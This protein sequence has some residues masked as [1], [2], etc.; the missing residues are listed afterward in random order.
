MLPVSG[1]SE[2]EVSTSASDGT[3]GFSEYASPSSFPAHA[4]R[5]A[6]SATQRKSVIS[7]FRFSFIVRFPFVRFLPL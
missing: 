1:V 3:A 7:F 2:F 4:V 5:A 6:I